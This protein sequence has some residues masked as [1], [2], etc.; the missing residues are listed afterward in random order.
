MNNYVKFISKPWGFVWIRRLNFKGAG[1]NRFRGG[2][3]RERFKKN[4]KYSERIRKR[5]LRI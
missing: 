4:G 5:N 2:R 1:S 3:S